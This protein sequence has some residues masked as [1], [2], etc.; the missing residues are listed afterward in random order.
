MKKV[1]L[2]LVIMISILLCYQ[3][4][5]GQ[6]SFTSNIW[7]NLYYLGWA[8]PNHPL[9]FWIGGIGAT[10]AGL[11]DL[12]VPAGGLG[13]TA[14]GYNTPA[15]TSTGIANSF[16][17]VN[18]GTSLTTG[19]GNSFVGYS[20][21]F[22][23]N[24][25]SL[26]TF[27]GN[28]AGFTNTVGVRNTF[29]GDAAGY[30]NTGISNS[31]DGSINTFVG[32]SCG[33]WNTIG[34]GNSY[35]GVH[36]GYSTTVGKW[37]T[38]MGVRAGYNNTSG[39]NNCFYGKD[40]GQLET[41]D[42]ADTYIGEHSGSDAIGSWNSFLGFQA[43]IQCHG[44]RNTFAGMSSGQVSY[45]DSNAFFGVNS[46]YWHYQNNKNTYIG[47]DAQNNYGTFFDYVNNLENSAAIGA[48]TI[49]PD[50]NQMVLGDT[51]VHVGIGLSNDVGPIFYPAFPY[52]AWYTTGNGGPGNMLE[53]NAR[54]DGDGNYLGYTRPSGVHGNSGLRFRSLNL[55]CIPEDNNGSV[56]SVNAYGDVILVKESIGGNLGYC[57]SAMGPIVLTDFAATDLHEFNYNY[58]V[59]TVPVT[60]NNSV[61]IGY[62]ICNPT[63]LATLD[64]RNYTQPI[65]SVSD[66]THQYAGKFYQTGYYNA[67]MGTD[68]MVGVYGKS[69]VNSPLETSIV[70]NIGGD[71]YATKASWHNIGARG[72]ADG[73]QITQSNIGLEGN[74]NN[75]EYCYGV[76][77]NA[78]GNSFTTGVKGFASSKRAIGID[79]SAFGN[80]TAAVKGGNFIGTGGTTT[81]GIQTLAQNGSLNGLTYYGV[82][83]TANGL[84]VVPGAKNYGVLGTALGPN[85]ASAFNCGVKG[86]TPYPA[87]APPISINYAVYGDLGPNYCV[88]PFPIP[89]PIMLPINANAAGYFNGDLV[90]TSALWVS[91]D[92][93]LKDSIQD[94]SHPMS[95]LNQLHPKSYIFNLSQNESMMLQH[96]THFGLLAQDLQNVLPQLTKDMVHPARY[97]SL[98]NEIFPAIN[99]KAVNYVE[100]I[101]YLICAAKQHDS[102]INNQDSVI[103]SLQDQI[104]NLTTIIN[105]CCNA[106]QAPPQNKDGGNNNGNGGSGNEKKLENGNIHAIELSNAAGSPIIY[107]NIPNPFNSTNGGTK[108]RYFVPDN[109]NSPQI[110]FFDEFGEKLSTYAI[111]ETGMGEL[112]VTASNLSSGVYSYSLIINGKVIDTKKMIFQK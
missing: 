82:E 72:T 85:V 62:D 110:V 88:N 97:D 39:S 22:S 69:D 20:S 93:N 40:A 75:N 99:F 81:Y 6:A 63:L 102:T 103:H 11:I 25:G 14:F 16:F 94:L 89:C 37:N 73:G 42:T 3:S 109:T 77:G 84:P 8:T 18:A 43:G 57:S 91:S 67:L 100:I 29:V 27:I 96:G 30:W 61:G 65:P 21:G 26:N 36:T 35:L 106:Q 23:N 71:F 95:I 52:P 5:K 108:I 2:N 58:L 74:G 9:P 12:D 56:L 19:I 32:D 54:W 68:D 10:P 55:N 34:Y 101:P 92:A 15:F 107:Q 41:I 70:D 45:S 44:I 24:A 13:N 48:N 51:A 105:N 46:G 87:A 49:V 66:Y 31:L 112:D 4:S 79:G 7:N 38:F 50:N 111:L 28:T 76:V 33:F 80:N 47:F 60:Q 78:N 17:G 59:P 64:V 53:I 104:N 90:S 1:T 86:Y 83:A 98:D